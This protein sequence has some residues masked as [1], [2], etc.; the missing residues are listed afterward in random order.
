MLLPFTPL[1]PAL[2]F[3]PLPASFFAFLA[4]ATLTYLVVVELVKRRL[5]ARAA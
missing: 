4:A 5:F 1:A 2:G 3:V